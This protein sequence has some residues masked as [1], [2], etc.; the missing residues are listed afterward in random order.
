MKWTIPLG[1]LLLAL[2][3]VNPSLASDE[4]PPRAGGKTDEPITQA[5]FDGL[6]VMSGTPGYVKTPL[7]LLHYWSLGRGPT[8]VLLHQGPLFAVEFA[9]IQP[10][11]AKQGFRTLAVDIPAFGFSQRPDHPATG[12]EYAASFAALLDTLGIKRAA[13]AGTHTGATLA[14]AFAARYPK[15][16]ACL[17]LQGIPVYSGEEL[18]ERLYTSPPDTRI[19]SDG[20]HIPLWWNR[21]VTKQD[22]S[23]ASPES[24][25][26]LMIGSM[27]SGDVN[28]YGPSTGETFVTRAFDSVAAL[29]KVTAPT[30]IMSVKGNSLEP[31]DHRA[32]KLR[33]DFTLLEIPAHHALVTYDDPD[34]WAEAVGSFARNKCS[35][36]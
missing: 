26:W 31:S 17:T 6:H 5:G 3:L 4:M 16:T 36:M 25:Q 18:S 8:I 9:K 12:D 29:R 13:F 14:L 20:R 1:A 34:L 7:G 2:K 33:P 19:Y 21:V 28:W 23:K 27:L 10:L 15:R 30:L 35:M 32:M 22:L 11:L 24:L